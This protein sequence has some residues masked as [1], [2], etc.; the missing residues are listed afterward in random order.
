MKKQ[1]TI[2]VTIVLE[3]Q[4]EEKK[5]LRIN[6]KRGVNGMNKEILKKA[7]KQIGRAHV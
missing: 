3:K 2:A 6:L 5:S 7:I 4:V 1:L